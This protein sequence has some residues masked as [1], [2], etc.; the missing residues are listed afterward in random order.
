MKRIAPSILLLLWTLLPPGA[1]GQ[2]NMERFRRATPNRGFEGNLDLDLTIMTGNTDFRMI[3]LNS[4]F[5][6]N[7]T[8]AYTFLVLNGGIG[9]S[10]GERFMDQSTAHLRHV[11]TLSR[12]LQQE[13][14]LQFDN[15][16]KRNL[17]GRELVGIGLRARLLSARLAKLRCGA[18]WMYEFERYDLAAGNRHPRDLKTHRLSSYLTFELGR[19]SG[20]TLL[21]VT[22][23]QP[24]LDHWRDHRLLSENALAMT[25][26][27]FL[28]FKFSFNFRRDSRPPDGVRKL[29][30]TTKSTFSVKF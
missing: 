3:G 4:R 5:N 10:G 13:S 18:A 9:W 2:I 6:Y 25:L 22:Y 30:T 14:F 12:R 19:E 28:S 15:N 8:N 27:S 24:A 20:V 29:D 23:F 1:H 7:W 16:R 11:F 21:S 26:T 17:S